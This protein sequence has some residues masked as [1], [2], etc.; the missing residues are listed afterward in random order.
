MQQQ[1]NEFKKEKNNIRGTSVI[2]RS[3]VKQHELKLQH[4]HQHILTL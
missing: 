1:L 3:Q 4:S 2:L